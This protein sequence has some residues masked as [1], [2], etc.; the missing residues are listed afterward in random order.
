MEPARSVVKKLAVPEET[1]SQILYIVLNAMV[2]NPDACI[3]RL[4]I[5]CC[6][7]DNVMM[8]LSPTLITRLLKFNPSVLHFFIC[9]KQTLIQ[10]SGLA[11]RTTSMEVL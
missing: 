8:S 10:H 4:T 3:V 2:T 7:R 6:T 9:A 1:L 5:K 11:V